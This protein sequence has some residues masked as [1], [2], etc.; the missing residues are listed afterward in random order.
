MCFRSELDKCQTELR[1]ALSTLV[2]WTNRHVMLNDTSDTEP[3]ALVTPVTQ[4]IQVVLVTSVVFSNSCN[5]KSISFQMWHGK[6]YLEY[7]P[8][9]C[10]I[11]KISH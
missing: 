3:S 4:L 11:Y 8:H 7:S 2:L 9:L 10:S 1:Q 6:I 5:F